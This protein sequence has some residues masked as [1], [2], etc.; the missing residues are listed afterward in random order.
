MRMGF[1]PRKQSLVVDIMP[2]FTDPATL[3]R[4]GKHKTGRSCLYITRLAHVDMDVL[5]ELAR[6]AWD[7]MA[8]R[9][10]D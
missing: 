3:E 10:P 4:L 1:S 8:E 6:A 7:T 2:G 5:E 9:Y